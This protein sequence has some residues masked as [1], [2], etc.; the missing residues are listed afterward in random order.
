MYYLVKVVFFKIP[1]YIYRKAL[2]LSNSSELF[3]EVK[4]HLLRK[5]YMHF[6]YSAR[7]GTLI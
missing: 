2:A 3:L 5:S 1:V 7:I 4:S 6:P